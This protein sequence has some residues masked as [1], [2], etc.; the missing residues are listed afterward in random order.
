MTRF[1]APGTR[2]LPCVQVQ[3]A[4]NI[5]R[6]A[7]TKDAVVEE[8]AEV[9]LALNRLG[10]PRGDESRQSVTKRLLCDQILK[11]EMRCVCDAF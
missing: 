1:R 2:T 5:E 11:R 10:L 8:V 7:S 9:I 6:K 3:V 4:D